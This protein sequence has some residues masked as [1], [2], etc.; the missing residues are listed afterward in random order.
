LANFA[1][2]AFAALIV[3]FLVRVVGLNAGLP[4]LGP[5]AALAAHP[6]I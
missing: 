3:V 6:V 5:L 2:D 4:G 1:L